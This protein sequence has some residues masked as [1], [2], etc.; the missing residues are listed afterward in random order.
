MKKII[1]TALCILLCIGAGAQAKIQTKKYKIAD[2]PDK[3]MKVVLTGSEILDANLKEYLQN[4][5]SISPYEFCTY[6]DFESMKQNEGYYFLILTDSQFRND[7]QA[8]I[9]MFTLYKGTEKASNNV[10][11]LYEVISIPF[12]S[13]ADNDGKE[14]NF[15]PLILRSFQ[16]Q[17]QKMMAQEFIVTSMVEA[18]V[19]KA[20]GK[21]QDRVMMTADD[22]AF[23][24]NNSIK[25]IYRHENI[26][27]VPENEVQDVVDAQKSGYLVA[28]TVNP[29]EGSKGSV[30][31]KMLFNAA[32]SELFYISKHTVSVKNPAG[33]TQSDLKKIIKHKDTKKK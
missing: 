16:M 31:F 9:K 21:W 8:G 17:V 3:T 22:I 26:D 23:E 2:L 12:C 29:P 7:R 24:V 25:A 11:G 6:T 28:Y 18:K 5:W 13:A 14:I 10:K 1:F 19:D 27:I 15:L 33:F 30:C 4:I 32:T 20:L